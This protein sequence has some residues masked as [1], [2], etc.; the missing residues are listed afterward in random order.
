MSDFRDLDG[1]NRPPT[2]WEREQ[3]RW[4][5]ESAVSDVILDPEETPS[6]FWEVV[7][8]ATDLFLAKGG[9]AVWDTWT[10]EFRWAM[11]LPSLKVNGREAYRYLVQTGHLPIGEAFPR[12]LAFR[13]AAVEIMMDT[14]GFTDEFTTRVNERARWHR[15][16]LRIER[17]RFVPITQEHA[18]VELVQPSLLLLS[19]AA[20]ADVDT[21]YR[22]AF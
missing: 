1:K 12:G 22:K 8:Q 20:L 7:L 2:A 18:H 6:G 14:T 4:N 9:Q 3:R 16:G 21:L 13:L 10:A 11:S 17:N 19:N 5:A 15:V